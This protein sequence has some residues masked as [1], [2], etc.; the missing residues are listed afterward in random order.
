VTYALEDLYRPFIEKPYTELSVQVRDTR[1]N[2]TPGYLE[3]TDTNGE[4][5][6]VAN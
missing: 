1:S 3:V 5:K 2:T 6:I 4:I